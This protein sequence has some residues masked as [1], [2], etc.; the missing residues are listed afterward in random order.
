[1]AQTAKRSIPPIRLLA[2]PTVLE[3]T[4]LK[5]QTLYAMMLADRF[6]RPVKVGKRRVAWREA[7]VA[8]WIESRQYA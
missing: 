2:L 4:T 6:P 7:D 8:T 3:L 1:M 5:R